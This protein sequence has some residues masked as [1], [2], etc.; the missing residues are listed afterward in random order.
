[1]HCLLKGS[2]AINISEKDNLRISQLFFYLQDISLELQACSAILEIVDKTYDNNEVEIFKD[3]EIIHL[4]LNKIN[5]NVLPFMAKISHQNIIL[6]ICRFAEAIKKSGCGKLLNTY[7]PESQKRFNIFLKDYYTD[8]IIKYRNCYIAHPMDNDT[9]DFIPYKELIEL[10]ARTLHIKTL[11]NLTIG[12]FL[13]F[14]K[15][16]HFLDES[17]PN[18]SLTWAI[19]GMSDELKGNNIIIS[20]N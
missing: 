11:E 16:M 7:C 6:N 5:L 19:K 9:N 1:L 10:S 18:K 13:D 15:R 4:K 12:D 17:D 14:L 8:E 2:T 3:K 20:R